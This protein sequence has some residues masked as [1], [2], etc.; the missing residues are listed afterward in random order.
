MRLIALAMGMAAAWPACAQT[1]GFA[2]PSASAQALNAV[3]FVSRA[4]ADPGVGLSAHDGFATPDFVGESLSGQPALAGGRVAATGEGL[5]AW[6][7]SQVSRAAG[8]GAVDTVRLST[9][10]LSRTPLLGAP[11]LGAPL[12]G[13]H[14]AYDPAAVNVALVRGWPAAMIVRAGDIGVNVTPHAGLGFGAA[15]SSAEA[16]ATLKITSVKDAINDRLSAMGVKNG[17]DAYRDES[18][19]YLF[20]AVRGQAV[21]LNMQQTGG[22]LRRAG[23]STDQSSALVGDGQIGVGWRKGGMEATVGYVH[24]GV[25]VKNAPLGVTD[26]Y[27]DDMAALSLT[28]HPHF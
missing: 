4:P 16:G 22:S 5:I 17:A 1:G 24:R 7:S 26:S 20:A 14:D 13:A 12:L 10:S 21:G 28:F 3:A 2:A 6:R 19:I 25:H 11:L 27:A 18:R 15:G 9:A 8:G 23:W